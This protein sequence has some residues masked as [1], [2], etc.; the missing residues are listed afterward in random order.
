MISLD[1]KTVP[2]WLDLCLLLKCVFFIV[3]YLLCI[4]VTHYRDVTWA[5]WC[6]IS[7]AT[8]LFFQQLFWLT[9]GKKETLLVTEPLCREFTNHQCPSQRSAVQKW[10]CCNAIECFHIVFQRV[11][12]SY[13]FVVS[14]VCH[15]HHTTVQRRMPFWHDGSI[16][17]TII[18]N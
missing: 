1:I 8:R 11:C 16:I 18:V 4:Y 12:V 13:V 10:S 5:W 9:T 17:E 7:P 2:E 6:F 3:F 14:C 15:R